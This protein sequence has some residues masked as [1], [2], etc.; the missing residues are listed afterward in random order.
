MEFLYPVDQSKVGLS[1]NFQEHLARPGYKGNGGMDFFS[2]DGRAGLPILSSRGGRVIFAGRS[3]G[4]FT[5]YGIRVDIDHGGGYQSRYAH[6]RRAIV[7]VNLYVGAGVQI[8]E[9]GSTG[10][11]TGNHVHFEIIKNGVGI[12]PAPLLLG[13]DD[14]IPDPQ[15]QPPADLPQAWRSIPALPRG[16]VAA[17]LGV[18][19][20]EAPA[21]S[22]NFI[23]L[24]PLGYKFEIQGVSK[25]GA[26]I[27]LEIGDRQYL[28][29][30][31]AGEWL[32][33]PA[34]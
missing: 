21:I 13:I 7:P 19:L 8:G 31:Y 30:Y 2:L 17:P 10:N 32:C 34:S 6:L 23:R 28:A 3:T 12:D 5:A 9:M 14:D 1:D 11:S 26:D 18:R 33:K 16:E 25:S 29:A 15:P 27:W 22:G 24:L 20:R 4:G